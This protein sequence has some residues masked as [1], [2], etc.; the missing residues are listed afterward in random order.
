MSN[1]VKW[2]GIISGGV[3]HACKGCV[4]PIHASDTIILTGCARMY[5]FVCM[6]VLCGMECNNMDVTV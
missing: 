5:S 6:N 3:S 4:L 2:Y 1:G